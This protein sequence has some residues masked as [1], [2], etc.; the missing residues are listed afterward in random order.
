MFN[1]NKKWTYLRMRLKIYKKCI[2]EKI[3]ATKKNC[4]V[5]NKERTQMNKNKLPTLVG[6][7]DIPE[8]FVKKS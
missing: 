1:G 7:C 6:Y 3:A 5:L 4:I 8:C 2:K